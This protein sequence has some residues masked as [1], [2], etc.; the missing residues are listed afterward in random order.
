MN[1]RD[2]EVGNRIVTAATHKGVTNKTLATALGV[3]ISTLRRTI[4][5][6]RSL[7]IS[8]IEIIAKTI[9]VPAFALLPSELT[10]AA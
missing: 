9:E 2:V 7:T 5:G 1:A 10:I 8:Q 4:R 3:S 6:E